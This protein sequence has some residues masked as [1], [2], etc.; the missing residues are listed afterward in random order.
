MP[1]IYHEKLLGR[2]HCEETLHQHVLVL[3][4]VIGYIISWLRNAKEMAGAFL[5]AARE[6]PEGV[7][8][9]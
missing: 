1:V 8:P 9:C 6:G 4:S 3:G 7:L 2:K 5:L